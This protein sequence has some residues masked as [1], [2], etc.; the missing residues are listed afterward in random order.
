MFTHNDDSEDVPRIRPPVQLDYSEA[1][2]RSLEPQGQRRHRIL[3]LRCSG[4]RAASPANLRRTQQLL[5]PVFHLDAAGF[6]DFVFGF[7]HGSHVLWPTASV[8]EGIHVTNAGLQQIGP[9]S[10]YDYRMF[11]DWRIDT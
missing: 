4:C 11:G 6:D 5:R 3:P 9:R 10:G 7:A 8:T 1:D 2:W